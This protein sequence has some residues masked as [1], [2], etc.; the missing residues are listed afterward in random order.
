MNNINKYNQYLISIVVFTL[1]FLEFVKN[2][3]NEIDIILDK[4]FYLLFLVLFSLLIILSILINK[5]NKKLSLE[6]VFI[7]VTLSYWLIFKHNIINFNLKKSL[8][9]FNS[10][11]TSF[12][13]EISILIILIIIIF[14]Y[15]LIKKKNLFFQRFVFIFFILS[16]LVSFMGIFYNIR[17]N[18]SE[19]NISSN[20]IFNDYLNKKKNNIYFFILDAMQP[21]E[22]FEKH[23]NT[24]LSDFNKFINNYE[25]K[26]KKD[27]SNLYDNTTHSLSAIF[28]LQDIFDENRKLKKDIN[29]LYPTLLRKE[30]QSVL[31][32]NLNNL[33]Y[34]FKWIG[35][36]FHIAQN[37]I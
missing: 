11:L 33:E 3:I 34:D 22:E 27:T 1:P 16:F 6:E 30:N 8:E 31:I 37:L 20:L 28:Y 25:Y 19:N 15:F 9:H 5:F 24:D 10:F 17:N 13:S 12:S 7:I 18:N 29:I 4:S 21:I 36:Y 32:N 14:I 2:N 23:Y 26:Y 35:N